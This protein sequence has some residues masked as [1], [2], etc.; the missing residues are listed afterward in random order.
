MNVVAEEKQEVPKDET[1]AAKPQNI[2]EMFAEAKKEADA[3]IDVVEKSKTDEANAQG[4]G[5]HEPPKSD[6]QAAEGTEV[7]L[8]QAAE[9]DSLVHS[10]TPV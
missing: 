8:K 2:G 10:S 9:C 6:Q 5:Q 4:G 3:E 7:V 1:P